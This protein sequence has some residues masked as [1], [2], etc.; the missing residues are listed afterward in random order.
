[1]F[2]IAAC[3]LDIALV[4][5]HS[6]SVGPASWQLLIDLM[7]TFVSALEIGAQEMRVA[8]VSFGM[9]LHLDTQSINIAS[10]TSAIIRQQL[11]YR[12]RTVNLVLHIAIGN[13]FLVT[14]VFAHVTD[15]GGCR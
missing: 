1:M 2:V 4:L 3:A 14:K 6:S 10:T 9:Q 12:Q 13:L 11:K 7:V 15:G 5:D 8:S